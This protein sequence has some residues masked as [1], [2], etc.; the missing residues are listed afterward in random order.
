V[1]AARHPDEPPLAA[2]VLISTR[3]RPQMLL[4]TVRSIL[5]ASRLPREL[6]VIDQ[7]KVPNAEVAN[8][9]TV[10]GCEV[11]YVHSSTQGLGRARNLGFRLASQE[12]VVILHDD[13]F[14][15]DDSLERLLAGIPTG[16]TR[17][18]TTG[19]MLAAPPDGPG[20]AQPPAAL[21]TR[22]EPA[23][24]RGRQPLQ[25]VPGGNFAVPRGAVLEIGGYDERIGPGTAFPAAEDNDLSLRLLD[26]GCE[27]RHVPEAV[28]LHR[29]WRSQRDLVRLRWAY[30][31]GQGGFYAK[32]ASVRD[33]YALGRAAREVR[34]R[35]RRAVTSVISSPKTTAAELLT[36]A[37]LLVGAV[38]WSWRYRLRRRPAS[39][40]E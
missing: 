25:V 5:S 6:L 19:R 24:F 22:T 32:H 1:N 35:V 26:I 13:M 15:R 29:S 39:A 31:R 17:T 14:V 4:D 30:A 21:V 9:G 7:S 3:E 37:G 2:T 20:L 10:R 34:T 36:L 40:D 27:V 16:A 18:I 8:L 38:E 28:V 23:V 33:P 12:I 11:R